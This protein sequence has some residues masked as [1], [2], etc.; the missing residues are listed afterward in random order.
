MGDIFLLASFLG[1]GILGYFL[2]GKLDIFLAENYREI[3]K[4]REISK[5]K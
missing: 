3:E 4:K 1:I 5:D 2:M